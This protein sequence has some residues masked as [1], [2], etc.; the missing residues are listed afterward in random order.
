MVGA[1]ALCFCG[2]IGFANLIC[3]KQYRDQ[4]LHAMALLEVMVSQCSLLCFI[5]GDDTGNL[6]AFEDLVPW[7]R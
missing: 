7:P 6:T 4:D 1:D 5:K 3:L 2:F